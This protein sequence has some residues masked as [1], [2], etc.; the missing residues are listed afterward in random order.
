GRI[1]DARAKT[2][3]AITTET[4]TTTAMGNAV[5]TGIGPEVELAPGS[6]GRVDPPGR[7]SDWSPATMAGQKVT[8][9]PITPTPNRY[10]RSSHTDT[11]F[12]LVTRAITAA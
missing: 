10:P 4:N 11:V 12:C 8:S 2:E 5:L 9:P 1:R 7:A 6:P 3:I